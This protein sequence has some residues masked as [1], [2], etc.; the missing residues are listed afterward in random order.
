[1]QRLFST[2]PNQWPGLGLLVLRLA[3]GLS[4]IEVEHATSMLGDVGTLLIRFAG[5]AIALLLVVGFATPLAGAGIAVLQIGLM[6]LE[7]RYR[8][9]AVVDT[10]LGVA[11]A[12]LGPGAWSLDAEIFGR[13]RIV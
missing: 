13:K 12:L 1:V 10:A 3:A 4:L 6:I 9:P 5:L 2:F 11:V 7:S 8:L